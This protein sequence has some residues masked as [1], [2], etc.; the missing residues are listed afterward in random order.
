VQRFDNRFV[1]ERFLSGDS[2]KKDAAEREDVLALIDLF[3]LAHQTSDSPIK[4][5]MMHD[6]RLNLILADRIKHVSALDR[7]CRG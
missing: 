7:E 4:E 2:F 3:H 5:S 6:Y 1:G